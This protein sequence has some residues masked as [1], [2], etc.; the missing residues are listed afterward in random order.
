MMLSPS[1][2]YKEPEEASGVSINVKFKVFIIV[3]TLSI[4]LSIPATC[5]RGLLMYDYFRSYSTNI[6]LHCT[7]TGE[8]L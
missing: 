1:T 6:T 8:L 5:S 3:E 2:K 7:P 4:I